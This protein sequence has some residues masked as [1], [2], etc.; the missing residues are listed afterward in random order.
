MAFRLI[1][2]VGFAIGIA[3][4]AGNA[5]AQ[6]VRPTPKPKPPTPVEAAQQ[7]AK[8]AAAFEFLGTLARTCFLPPS[9]SEDFRDI[10]APYVSDPSKAP[11]RASWY[12]EPAKVFDNLYFVGGK[13][14]SAVEKR[15]RLRGDDCCELVAHWT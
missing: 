1:P 15:C 6:Q 3:A 7:V 12:A 8:T 5:L 13:V 4:I 11:A 10:P 9:R 2:L 14:H